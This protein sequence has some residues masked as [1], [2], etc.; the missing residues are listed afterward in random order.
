ME[1]AAEKERKR[2]KSKDKG[3]AFSKTFNLK[4]KYI[5]NNEK[6]VKIET[7]RKIPKYRSR[8][9]YNLF[10]FIFRIAKI[11]ATTTTDKRRRVVR[12][13]HNS[14]ILLNLP[15]ALDLYFGRFKCKI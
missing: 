5:K 13:E 9:S 10:D 8:A 15:E 12:I 2:S 1:I 6:N 4:D 7:L 14:N 3:D 11:I